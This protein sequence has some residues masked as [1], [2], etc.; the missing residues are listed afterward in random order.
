MFSY[1]IK[2]W[3]THGGEK[4]DLEIESGMDAGEAWPWFARIEHIPGTYVTG[5]G[6]GHALGRLLDALEDHDASAAVAKQL[7]PETRESVKFYVASRLEN[8]ELVQKVI[9]ALQ[10]RNASCTYDWT[11]AGSVTGSIGDLAD[12]ARDERD[13]VELADFVIVLLPGGR[14]THVE[15]GM[16][17][18]L[19]KQV[20]IWSADPALIGTTSA[21]SAFYHLVQTIDGTTVRA[22][23][24]AVAFL[25]TCRTYGR[26]K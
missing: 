24:A 26:G 16:A 1:L 13:G 4:L 6:P 2:G 15:L 9:D 18:A 12:V 8:T 5:S 11:Q 22:E 3:R 17:I 7:E 25:E 19:K 23:D 21:T 14:G 10:A 20:L